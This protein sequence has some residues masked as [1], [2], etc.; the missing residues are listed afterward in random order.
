MVWV[1]VARRLNM[2]TADFLLC[3]YSSFAII[4]S[5]RIECTIHASYS[6]H[7]L[8]LFY[9]IF[10]SLLV[11]YYFVAMSASNRVGRGRNR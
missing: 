9:F 1:T 3:F 6:I 11:V 8:F 10:L 4:L 5:R 7:I 2:Y